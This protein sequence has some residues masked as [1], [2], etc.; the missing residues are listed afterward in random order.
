[1]KKYQSFLTENFQFLDVKF[2]IFSN[3]RVFVM[4]VAKWLALRTGSLGPGPAG[5][6]IQ[7]MTVRTA[8]HCTEPFCI[9]NPWFQHDVN[10]F[11]WDVK[12]LIINIRGRQFCNVEF[13]IMCI[14][15]FFYMG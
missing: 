9:T 10:N 5:S 1:M 4:L 15:H 11:E 13:N 7:L 3:R 2:S 8:L 14:I 6:G 12:H